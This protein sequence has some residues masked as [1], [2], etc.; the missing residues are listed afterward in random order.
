MTLIMTYSPIRFAWNFVSSLVGFTN[1]TV[2]CA[3][4]RND[5]SYVIKA[6]NNLLI[7]IQKPRNDAESV[8][9]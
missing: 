1:D 9:E 2:L 7:E 5:E 4:L 3:A 8:P 6:P